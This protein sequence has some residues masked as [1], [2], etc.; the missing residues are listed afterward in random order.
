[1]ARALWV[2]VRHGFGQ[3]LGGRRV[4]ITGILVASA[5]IFTFLLAFALTGAERANRSSLVGVAIGIVGVGML[6]GVDAGGGSEALVGGLFVIG[7]AFGY[8]V[9]AWHLP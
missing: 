4:W 2:L 6:L 3:L 9:A 1:M 8:A 7:A 5:P